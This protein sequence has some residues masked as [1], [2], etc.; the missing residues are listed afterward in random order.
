MDKRVNL[1]EDLIAVLLVG[2]PIIVSCI[3][4]PVYAIKEI[5]YEKEKRKDKNG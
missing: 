2:W 3:L 4:Y 5:R 1:L